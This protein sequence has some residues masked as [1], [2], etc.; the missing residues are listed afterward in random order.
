MIL[1]K[2][3]SKLSAKACFKIAIGLI[4]FG[5]LME[6]VHAIPKE[7]PDTITFS[8]R[9]L[10]AVSL[11][12]STPRVIKL[13]SAIEG[14]GAYDDV[15]EMLAS[16]N[17]RDEV[18]VELNSPGGSVLGGI[19]LV[20]ALL[21]TKAHVTTRIT[22]GAYSMAAVLFC[23]GDTKVMDLGTVLMFHDYS[24]SGLTGKGNELEQFTLSLTR[25]MR[26]ILS[27]AC[28]EIL[29]PTDIENILSGKDLYIHPADLKGRLTNGSN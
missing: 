22:G 13:N 18:I 20:N 7:E 12:E 6:H 3:T 14:P 26:E 17:E 23:T 10:E 4:L 11:I 8:R 21:Q 24:V 19:P 16:L 28:G 9:P 15:I 29:T 1:D 27:G 5:L 25:M 2:L